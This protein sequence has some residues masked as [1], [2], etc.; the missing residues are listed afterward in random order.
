MLLSCCNVMIRMIKMMLMMNPVGLPMAM[1]VMMM[2]MLAGLL[3]G[4]SNLPA[5]SRHRSWWIGMQMVVLS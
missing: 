1:P 5:T 4:L 3:L 2:V